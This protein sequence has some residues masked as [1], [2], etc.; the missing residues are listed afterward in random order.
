M[1]SASR[2]ID[3]DAKIR[4]ITDEE[5]AFYEKNG[6]VKLDRLVDP[7]LADELRRVVADIP[8]QDRRWLAKNG[9]EPFRSMMFSEKMGQNAQRLANRRRFTDRDIAMRY[10]TDQIANK[11]PGG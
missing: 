10:R 4:E 7:E 3:V 2:S 1:V 8:N 5:I 11:S 9:V 6:W